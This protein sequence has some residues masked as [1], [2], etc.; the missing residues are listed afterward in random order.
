MG[1]AGRVASSWSVLVPTVQT[2]QKTVGILQVLSPQTQFIDG[3]CSLVANRDR[4]S[5]L[6]FLDSL[7]FGCGLQHIDK[8][9]DVRHAEAR[10]SDPSC[11]TTGARGVQYID[12][13]VDVPEL[14]CIAASGEAFERMSKNFHVLVLW[15]RKFCHFPQCSCAQNKEASG[16]VFFSKKIAPRE[17]GLGGQGAVLTRKSGH[18]FNEQLS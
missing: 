10:S 14:L 7:F 6:Q 15:S 5:Q 12:K 11:A 9:V 1:G 16:S 18:Y 2:V 17:G 8:N 4:I 3:E 13:V